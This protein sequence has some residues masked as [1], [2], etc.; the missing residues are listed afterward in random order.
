[1]LYKHSFAVRKPKNV[2]MYY[3]PHYPDHHYHHLHHH[4]L[5]PQHPHTGDTILDGSRT[6]SLT[7]SCLNSLHADFLLLNAEVSESS[8][9]ALGAGTFD[10]LPSNSATLPELVAVQYIYDFV[11]KTR[12]LKVSVRVCMRVF[13]RYVNK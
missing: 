9:L 3:Y 4:L 8:T 2:M 13:V 6:L 10:V 11:Q 1:M 7:T 12:S 5:Y